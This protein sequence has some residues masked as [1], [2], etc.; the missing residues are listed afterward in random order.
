MMQEFGLAF[1]PSSSPDMALRPPRGSLPIHR[2][3]KKADVR[4]LFAEKYFANGLAEPI[5]EATGVKMYSLSHISGGPYTADKFEVEMRENLDT[6]A[7]AIDST[8][9]QAA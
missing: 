3:I 1:L 9:K 2:R 8:G 5:E 4:V 7:Q 6:L